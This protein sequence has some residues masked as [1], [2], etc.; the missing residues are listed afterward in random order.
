[1]TTNHI[2]SST[3][4]AHI[5][6]IQQQHHTNCKKRDAAQIRARGLYNKS[7]LAR[8]VY[9]AAL[10][11]YNRNEQ[12]YK[13]RDQQARDLEGLIKSIDTGNVSAE[14]LDST[15]RMGSASMDPV[16]SAEHLDSTMRMGSASMDP[17]HSAEQYLAEHLASTTRMGSASMDPV[18]SAEQYSGEPAELDQMMVEETY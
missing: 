1:M 2:K 14:H 17:V 7:E 13:L 5:A 10:Q 3:L 15:T 16:H 8:R 18:H 9:L 12:E 11:R 4:S 6:D